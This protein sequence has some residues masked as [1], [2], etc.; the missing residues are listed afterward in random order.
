MFC[1]N[2]YITRYILQ[3]KQLYNFIN[4]C[5]KNSP[6]IESLVCIILESLLTWSKILKF[7]I[8]VRTRSCTK[9]ISEDCKLQQII[10]NSM[11]QMFVQQ[12]IHV[13]ILSTIQLDLTIRVDL[14]LASNLTVTFSNIEQPYSI[15]IFE[16][17]YTI[18][19]SSYALQIVMKY[20]LI[21]WWFKNYWLQVAKVT[22]VIEITVIYLD[23]DYDYYDYYLVVNYRNDY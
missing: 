3:Y 14:L 22:K 23:N 19:W 17:C 20:K 1:K 21:T 18:M 4:T 7:F 13:N 15:N 2:I 6:S 5:S 8:R 16:Q 12:R 10:L 9:T 11:I